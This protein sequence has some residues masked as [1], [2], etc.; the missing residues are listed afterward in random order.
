MISA[1]LNLPELTE[2]LIKKGADINVGNRIFNYNAYD[3]ANIFNFDKVKSI[4]SK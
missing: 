1:R 4:L 3:I 2:L